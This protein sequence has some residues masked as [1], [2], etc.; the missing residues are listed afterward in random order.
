MKL[1]ALTK[2]L[3]FSQFND[4]IL[5]ELLLDPDNIP[6]LESLLDSETQKLERLQKLEGKLYFGSKVSKRKL[7]PLF[8][9]VKQEVDSFLSIAGGSTPKY[10]YFSLLEPNLVSAGILGTYGLGGWFI[11]AGVTGVAAGNLFGILPTLAGFML[12]NFGSKLHKRVSQS[13]YNPI[14]KSINLEKK[15]RADLV[16]TIAHEYTHYVQNQVLEFTSGGF[17]TFMEGHARGVQR[18]T[19]NVYREKED[20]EAFLYETTDW[21]CGELKSTYQWLCSELSIHERQS[22]LKSKTSRDKDETVH[23]RIYRKPTPHAIGNTLFYL[24]ETQEGNSIYKNM[25]NETFSLFNTS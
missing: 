19:A 9:E 18:H 14:Y 5:K 4:T 10:D 13:G 16:S 15:Q 25:L 6:H 20:N 1:D 12:I 3:Y 21:T 11:L 2:A 7:K 22:L 8:F 24:Y 17:T 23:R